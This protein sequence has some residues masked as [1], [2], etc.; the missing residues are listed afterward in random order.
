LPE[1]QK[2]KLREVVREHD[3]QVHFQ[4]MQISTAA[5][6]RGS[7]NI[8]DEEALQTR[9]RDKQYA[10][11]RARVM[12]ELQRW[13]EPIPRADEFVSGILHHNDSDKNRNQ[14]FDVVRA[15]HSKNMHYL[16]WLMHAGV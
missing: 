2:Q 13:A 12:Q 10:R 14:L 8:Y 3:I 4:R 16:T 6:S 15:I 11:T 9:Q 5:G 1:E 7:K